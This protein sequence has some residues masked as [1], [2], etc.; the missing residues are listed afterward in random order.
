MSRVLS[1]HSVSVDGYITGRG[2]GRNTYD[3]SGWV[4]GGAAPGVTHLHYEVVR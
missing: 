4:H 3:D 1:A 2:P